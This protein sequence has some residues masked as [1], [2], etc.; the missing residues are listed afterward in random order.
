M[1]YPITS[2]DGTSSWNGAEIEHAMGW[3]INPTSNPQEFATN[4]TKGKRQRLPGIL[5]VTGTV[6]VPVTDGATVLFALPG[7]IAQLVLTLDTGKAWTITNAIITDFD[8]EVNNEDNSVEAINVNWA[9]AGKDDGNGGSIVTPDGT[10]W[11]KD[12]VG[13][14]AES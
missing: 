13:V 12:A 7:Q 4:K 10:T 11:D 3:T 14:I 2:V 1:S 9:F 5:D 6:R 8:L